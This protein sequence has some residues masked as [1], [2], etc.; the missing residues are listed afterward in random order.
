MKCSM[1]LIHI[2]PSFLLM[3]TAQTLSL[4]SWMI[5]PLTPLIEQIIWSVVN[6][7]QLMNVWNVLFVMELCWN[8]A[9]LFPMQFVYNFYCTTL[10]TF[11]SQLIYHKR[12][13]THS[14]VE[15]KHP[16]L[17]L[18]IPLVCLSSSMSVQFADSRLIYLW[19]FLT[20]IF[21]R[22]QNLLLFPSFEDAQ[23]KFIVFLESH[24][25]YYKTQRK[26]CCII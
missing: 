19:S 26:R 24:P 4:M 14:F 2:P 3:F 11:L 9:P 13:M 25:Q 15:P 21:S 18:H 5:T 17:Y 7:I 22:C 23:L 6:G 20:F 16:T 10:L 1:L 8:V 12:N